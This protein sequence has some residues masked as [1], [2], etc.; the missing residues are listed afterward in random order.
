MVRFVHQNRLLISSKPSQ[1]VECGRIR[2][3][4]YGKVS[5]NRFRGTFHIPSGKEDILCNN[6]SL[7]SFSFTPARVFTYTK[8]NT[9]RTTTAKSATESMCKKKIEREKK[10]YK[11]IFYFLLHFVVFA[12]HH[13]TTFSFEN[14]VTVG[15]S[16]GIGS[17]YLSS[18]RYRTSASPAHSTPEPPACLASC[19]VGSCRVGYIRLPL[20][21]MEND[22][23]V[24]EHCAA[25]IY[26]Y[27]FN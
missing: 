16:F 18:Y 14:F 27:I 5:S 17:F 2:I 13:L 21:D 20:H 7:Q 1:I 19:A 24:I 11:K 23:I 9:Q 26:T 12:S 22:R 8:R 4:L 10:T 6:S 3:T 25:I 15:I